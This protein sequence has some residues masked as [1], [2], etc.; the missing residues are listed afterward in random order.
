MCWIGQSIGSTEISFVHTDTRDIYSMD[1]RLGI[2]ALLLKDADASAWLGWSHD[3]NFLAFTRD[4]SLHILNVTDGSVRNYPVNLG[5]S[6]IQEPA[7][8]PDDRFISFHA[9]A[10]STV[11]RIYF[12]RLSDGVI[13]PMAEVENFMAGASWS[14]VTDG[15]TMRLAYQSSET[16]CGSDLYLREIQLV[17]D[18]PTTTNIV[19]LTNCGYQ[20]MRPEW[21]PDGQH[22][23]FYASPLSEGQRLS[24]P[25]V[26]ML[27]AE[28]GEREQVTILGNAYYPTWSADGTQIVFTMLSLTDLCR[29]YIMDANGD[30]LR[31]LSRD[32][33]ID[34]S[35]V[36]R[37]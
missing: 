30:N 1:V 19:R 35:A 10:G 37:P 33:L 6:G 32:M 26:Y 16:S 4:F 21:S 25:E 12:L 23:L 20:N 7:W 5:V 27:D 28:S 29:V 22:L 36:W 3:G 15:T 34:I 9:Q 18:V 31:C 14:P 17:D 8:S 2:S 11:F 24:P 13:F